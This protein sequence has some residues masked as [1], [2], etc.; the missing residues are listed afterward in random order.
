MIAGRLKHMVCIERKT[1]ALNEYGEKEQRWTQITRKRV[2]IDPISG[3][4]FMAASGEHA[5]VT[6][7]IRYRNTRRS[8]CVRPRDRIVYQGRTFEITSVI[9]REREVEVMCTEA[10]ND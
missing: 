9:A 8:E 2:S 1:D 7:R 5:E 10:I 6:H 4:E 3:R